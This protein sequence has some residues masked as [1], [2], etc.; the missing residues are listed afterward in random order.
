[1][2]QRVS[3]LR[4][5]AVHIALSLE[6]QQIFL[7]GWKVICRDQSG[8]SASKRKM[9]VEEWNAYIE[10]MSH[11]LYAHAGFGENRLSEIETETEL[12]V[13][14]P[15]TCWGWKNRKREKENMNEWTVQGSKIVCR[16]KK[17]GRN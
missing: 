4:T 3:R 12:I 8:V 17:I 15:C 2:K 9:L 11:C 5:D 7:V 16:R 6:S 14:R 13:I 10:V 1:M